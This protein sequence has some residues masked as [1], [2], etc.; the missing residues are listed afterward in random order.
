MHAAAISL[1]TYCTTRSF[2]I[3]REP[4]PT[5]GGEPWRAVD[6][7]L[8]RLAGQKGAY[9]AEE[10][11][12]L[13]AGRIAGVHL[14][15]GFGSYLEYLERVLGYPPR[16][17]IERLRVAEQLAHLPAME[18]ALAEAT[19]PWSAIRELTRVALPKNEAAWLEH[20]RGKTVREIEA[21]VAGRRQGDDPDAPPNPTLC[22]TVLRL[23]VSAET[24]ALFREARRRVDS[25][26]GERLD[27]DQ[28]LAALARAVLDGRA[29]PGRA[30]HQIAMTVCPRCAQA[31]VDGA[32]RE[33]P[34]VPA[35]VE[36]ARCD[37]QHLGSTR[38]GAPARAVQ[39]VPPAVRRMVLRRDHGRCVVT[40]CRAAR[41]IE[42]HH[43]VPRARGGTHE[44]SNLACLCSAHHRAV[45]NDLLR[46]EGT[47]PD[48]LRFTDAEGRSY[49]GCAEEDARR[50]LCFLWA[51]CAVRPRG[52]GGCRLGFS[53]TAVR[54]ALEKV[55]P[56]VGPMASLEALIRAGLA[57]LRPS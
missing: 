9:D 12:L 45:H 42:V 25:E 56:H 18:A 8:R 21:M 2:S 10:A 39:D 43:L 53:A 36:Q 54:A 38:E 57:A 11:R 46:I 24:L 29:D 41:G 32:G 6:A 20:V 17:A 51:P 31:T 34:V 15:L 30:S 3:A 49:G 7:A 55:A 35:A 47:A 33:A 40:G 50:A 52:R 13:R 26:T 23:E 14:H 5:W 44:A 48:Q 4:V 16:L 1:A 37:A 19:L 28:I 22:R 27:D